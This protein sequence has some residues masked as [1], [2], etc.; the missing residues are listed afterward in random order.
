MTRV[1]SG[2]RVALHHQPNA[3]AALVIGEGEGLGAGNLPRQGGGGAIG[4]HIGPEEA[5]VASTA[6]DVHQA[7]V[8]VVEGVGAQL[9]PGRMVGIRVARSR[10]SDATRAEPRG[11][12]VG[13][14]IPI[15][16]GVL[17][18]ELTARHDEA[19]KR[20][21]GRGLRRGLG[22]ATPRGAQSPGSA[23]DDGK[24]LPS[25]LDFSWECACAKAHGPQGL[26]R[27]RSRLAHAGGREPLPGDSLFDTGDGGQ[28]LLSHLVPPSHASEPT[29]R[30][31]HHCP[32]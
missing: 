3:L 8:V 25:H 7:A 22:V 4:S 11:E 28:G 26:S 9:L 21:R 19:W 15:G 29:F 2:V 16:A 17:V 24:E 6:R 31:L 12:E 27:A 10:P 14:S 32:A 13:Q 23:E 1:F 20:A 30:I 5:A 18:G